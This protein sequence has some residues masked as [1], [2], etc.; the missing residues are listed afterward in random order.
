MGVWI[1]QGENDRISTKELAR[2][3]VAAIEAAGGSVRYSEQKGVG[4]N[5]L[6]PMLKDDAVFTWLLEQKLKPAKPRR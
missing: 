5:S 3:L 2:K 1:M 4:H 6:A